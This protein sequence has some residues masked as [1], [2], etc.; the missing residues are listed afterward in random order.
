MSSVVI[1]TSLI[2]LV[3][4]LVCYALIAQTLAHKRQRRERLMTA[5]SAKVRNFKYMLNG[6]PQGFLPKDLLM[7][8]QR[9]LIDLYEQLVD[10]DSGNPTHKQDLQAI[11]LQLNET[12]RQTRQHQQVSIEN[13]QQ[14]KDAKACLEELHK[15]VFQLEQKGVVNRANADAYRS[16]IKQLVLQITVDS[17]M[18]SGRAAKGGNKTRLAI[19]YFTLAHKLLC[20]EGR[21]GQHEKTIAQL[22]ITIKELESHL[23]EEEPTAIVPTAQLPSIEELETS[24]A[25][26]KF[27][28]GEASWKKKQIYD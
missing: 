13:P 26:D 20:K 2:V 14:I 25:W 4:I 11:S 21:G 24:A 22:A 1:I 15:F 23:I 6:F 19:H 12:Q 17:Y 16:T 18:V 5:I 3:A 28:T 10:I 9:S 27:K 7:L 8:V